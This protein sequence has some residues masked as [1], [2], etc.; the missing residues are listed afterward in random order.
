MTVPG[1][2]FAAE[3]FNDAGAAANKICGSLIVMKAGSGDKCLLTR[4]FYSVNHCNS[5]ENML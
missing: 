2:F 5:S 4:F 1:G 3:S